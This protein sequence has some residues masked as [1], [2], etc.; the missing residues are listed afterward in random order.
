MEKVF[1]LLGSS[2]EQKI[3]LASYQLEGSVYD[4]LM[5]TRRVKGNEGDSVEPY[6]WGTFKESFKDKYFPRRIRGKMESDFITLEQGEKQT[7]RNLS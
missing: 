1:E 3:S 2:D 5:E 7:C 6:T 4:W